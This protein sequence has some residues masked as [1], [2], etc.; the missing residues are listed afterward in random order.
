ML[1]EKCPVPALILGEGPLWFRGTLYFVDIQA[2]ALY[3][4]R[5]GVGV[6]LRLPMPGCVGFAVPWGEALLVGAGDALCRVEPD[7]G[8]I[9]ALRRLALPPHLR[10]NDGKCDPQGRLWAGVMANDRTLPDV[11]LMGAL[12]CYEG[13]GLHLRQTLA[14]MDIPNGMAWDMQGHYYH[15]DSMN[16][17]IDRY[18]QLPDGRVADPEPAVI[19]HDG[20]PDGLCIDEE[21][22]LWVAQ[23][24]AG[25][26][27]RY[28]PATGRELP[29]RVELPKTNTSCCC[30]GG[31]D[32]RTLY[33]TTAEGEGETGGLYAA[34][35]G[36]GGPPPYAYGG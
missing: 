23:W 3:G 16:R 1:A 8:R 21:G 5:D 14:P 2:P 6:V 10:F 9:E 12:H 17:R 4:Y 34:R 13:A 28:D 31:A 35:P 20:V 15:T 7:T 27:Q 29:Q 24:G 32:M 30:F 19:I 25:R 33:I 26:V 11:H 36:V 18:R 22:M